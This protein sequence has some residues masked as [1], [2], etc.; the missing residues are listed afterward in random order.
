LTGSENFNLSSTT[1]TKYG[2][3]YF[4]V[5][6][7]LNKFT[8]VSL[9]GSVNLANSSLNHKGF[10]RL[11]NLLSS[12]DKTKRYHDKHEEKTVTAWRTVDHDRTYRP[13][14]LQW[15]LGLGKTQFTR[16][17]KALGLSSGEGRKHFYDETDRAEL[18]RF[19]SLLNQHNRLDIAFSK[20]S[21]QGQ[22]H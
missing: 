19:R 17:V 1:F 18:L 7:E 4:I 2:L 13:T 15:E 11:V 20:W 12:P 6:A 22:A 9:L 5:G 16:W 14:E 8:A 21:D 10:K 3:Y